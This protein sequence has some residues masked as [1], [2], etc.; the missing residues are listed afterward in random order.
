MRS[1]LADAGPSLGVCAVSA[2]LFV[3][4]CS[5]EPEKARGQK[6]ERSWLHALLAP[7]EPTAGAPLA[8]AGEPKRKKKPR[9]R[10]G[11]R[12]APETRD[13]LV[14]LARARPAPAP[15]ETLP[16]PT[17]TPPAAVP[18]PL[19]VALAPPP[20][21]EPAPERAAA[22]PA[23]PERVLPKPPEPEA[24]ETVAVAYSVRRPPQLLGDEPPALL[25][26]PAEEP[27]VVAAAPE[28]APAPA[29]V[30]AAPTAPPEPA[31]APKPVIAPPPKPAVVDEPAPAP[32]PAAPP[33]KPVVV[34]E[35][36]PSAPRPAP[37]PSPPPVVAPAPPPPPVIAPPAPP[38]VVA[39]PAP[40]P[41]PPPASFSP[42]PR[43]AVAAAPRPEREPKP[44]RIDRPRR[45]TP[46][47]PNDATRYL[48]QAWEHHTGERATEEVISVL[49][50][51]WAL[52][53]GRGRWMVDYNYAGLK[54]RA[55]DG[56]TANWWTWEEADAG[57]R[58]VRARFR[59]YE[60]PEHG[61]LD[62][63]EMLLRRYPKA[64]AAARRGDAVNFIL[65]LDH[66]GFFT[67][68]PEHYVRSVA[69]L[70]REFRRDS[71]SVLFKE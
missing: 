3:H 38:P 61:A 53:T 9:L 47:S 58:R 67:E 60:A 27:A 23:K 64:V 65:E 31:S 21:P 51:Q 48:A 14:V 63:V 18:A 56:G 40:A 13:A 66:G 7:A 57:A 15:V 20:K 22:K 11:F 17:R 26:R 68:R 71:Y 29:R 42:A 35:P 24:A 43:A 49:W 46:M 19:K 28:P 16:A 30:V 50:G 62:Y 2:A 54:G 41:V 25:A 10:K 44:K 52:E 6:P 33:P 5:A 39:P 59:S 45:P 32:K 69:S 4:A 1:R 55:P 36:T 70:A 12:I 8:A 34:A 37:A